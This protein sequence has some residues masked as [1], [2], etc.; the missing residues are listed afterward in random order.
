MKDF[1]NNSDDNICLLQALSFKIPRT[2][3]LN[4]FQSYKTQEEEIEALEE[5]T[6]VRVKILICEN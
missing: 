5:P 3:P 2:N 4:C 1:V 6:N